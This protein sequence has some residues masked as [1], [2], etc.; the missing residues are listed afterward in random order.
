MLK[1]FQKDI[2][3]DM[4]CALVEGY[5]LN[6]IPVVDKA[7]KLY[8]NTDEL[9][10]WAK[11]VENP[12]K[13]RGF[14]TTLLEGMFNGKHNLSGV[15]VEL[16]VQSTKSNL[17]KRR[18]AMIFFPD[19]TKVD[20]LIKIGNITESV[21]NGWSIIVLNGKTVFGGGGDCERV[22]NELIKSTTN[23]I[24]IISAKMAQ[25]SFSEELIS[26]LYLAYDKGQDGATI[27]KMSRALTSNSPDK[28]ARIFSLSF[29]PNRD[30]KLDTIVFQ[31][32][33]N[34]VE[35]KDKTDI[36]EELKRV[37]R[38][39]DIFS[40]TDDGNAIKLE[41]D[42][43]VNQSLEKKGI[44]RV[45]GKKSDLTLLNKVQVKALLDG[46]IN[47]LRN[48][49]KERAETGKTKDIEPKT[50]VNNK[51]EKPSNN[52]I[53]KVREVI[54]SIIEHSDV[55]M[56]ASKNKGGKNITEA[57][58]IFE[59]N[60][61]TSIIEEEFGVKYDVIKYLYTTGII[62]SEWINLLHG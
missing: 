12:V 17:S 8:P 38:S 33:F 49:M 29:D 6:M 28:I 34:Q 48:E 57:L 25:R 55:I 61:W 7:K 60:N 11:F 46:N 36:R 53:E 56:I 59:E 15:D 51:V 54:I 40:C 43:Y 22:V 19:N 44:S 14:Y 21:L 30:D 18:I 50:S 24:L 41:I 31:A 13:G 32:A 2:N 1:F 42:D 27:Q 58:Q 26:E 10:S 9:P 47:Y 16:L 3:R 20:N 5:Q 4:V 52:D 23:N 62:K 37:Y 39:I 45:M 35:K